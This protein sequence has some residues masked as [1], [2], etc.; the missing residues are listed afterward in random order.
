M[1]KSTAELT[2]QCQQITW[3]K[4][5]DNPQKGVLW[6]N[7]N[8]SVSLRQA[9]AKESRGMVKGTSDLSY[10]S[11]DG[12]FYA[13]ENKIIGTKHDMRTL[14]DQLMFARQVQMCQDLLLRL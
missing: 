1:P 13:L 11:P 6:A 8:N 7:D 9:Q 10:L 12:T 14:I 5:L 3:F 2:M 4:S